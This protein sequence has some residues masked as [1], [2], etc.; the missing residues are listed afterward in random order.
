MEKSEVRAVAR[1]AGLRIAEKPESMEI[2]FVP[3]NDYR[4]LIR[5]KIPDRV[6]EGAFVTTS[7]Q[8]VGRHGGHQ[9]FTVGQR[10]GLGVALGRPMYV[11]AIDAETNTVVLG[12][13][14]ELERMEL[15]ARE[16]NWISAP[17]DSFRALVKIR[18][19]HSGAMAQVEALP[20]GRAR[21]VFDEPQRAITRGQ[22]AVFYHEDHVLGGG[23]IG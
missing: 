10:K 6:R 11:V 3:E 17:G 23:W 1:E 13:D 4:K 22:A 5:E 18:Y 8:A 21:V 19:N 7:G 15:E 16:V 14:R 20:D 2:C 9:L 12:E